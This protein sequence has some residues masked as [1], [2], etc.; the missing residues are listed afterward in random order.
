LPRASGPEKS[1]G[2]DEQLVM[3]LV[4][5]HAFAGLEALGQLLFGSR[6]CQRALKRT[7]KKRGAVFVGHRECL[8][9]AQMK[10]LGGRIICDIASGRLRRKPFAHVAFRGARALREFRRSL[11]TAG[12]EFFVQAQFVADANQCRVKRRTKIDESLAQEFIQFVGINCHTSS[13][14][15]K[16]VSRGN[17]CEL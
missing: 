13:M 15:S 8:L 3:M 9:F 6:R 12:G 14:R 7:R 16:K 10:F 11:R 1:L 17:V 2:A 4:P 5:A